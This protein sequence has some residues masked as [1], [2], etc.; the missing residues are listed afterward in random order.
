VTAGN[1]PDSV[2]HGLRNFLA[3]TQV[4]EL[5]VTANIYE[6]SARLKSF[7]MIAKMRDLI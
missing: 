2:I 1:S 3:Q 5:M 7:A 4:D 6:H